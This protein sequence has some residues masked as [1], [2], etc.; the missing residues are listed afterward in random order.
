MFSIPSYED[1]S[2]PHLRHQH[3]SLSTTSHTP[4]LEASFSSSKKSDPTNKIDW[5]N[6]EHSIM[7]WFGSKHIARGRP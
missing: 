7:A 3:L 2:M 4:S 6:V 1:D 5:L